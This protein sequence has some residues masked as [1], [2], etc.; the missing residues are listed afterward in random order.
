MR[1]EERWNID[2]EIVFFSTKFGALFRC[3]LF[4]RFGAKKF[5]LSGNIFLKVIELFLFCPFQWSGVEEICFIWKWI[6]PFVFNSAGCT[7]ENSFDWWNLW[8]IYRIVAKNG[9]LLGN[10]FLNKNR[11]FSPFLVNL[12]YYCRKNWFSSGLKY[13]NRGLS[14]FVVISAACRRKDSFFVGFCS[15]QNSKQTGKCIKKN[16]TVVDLIL[17]WKNFGILYRFLRF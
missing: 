4:Q 7:A 12:L 2:R 6:L 1:A 3:W 5:D 8:L 9:F 17:F 13:K 11:C 10:P 15:S 16:P 14:I